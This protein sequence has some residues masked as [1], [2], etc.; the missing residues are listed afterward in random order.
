[1]NAPRPYTLIAEVTHRCP[2]ACPYCSNPLE[3]VRDELDTDAWLRVLEDYL[4]YPPL[5]A[6]REALVS[7]EIGDP[8]GL[9]MKIVAT[10]RGGWDVPM[11]SYEWQFEQARDGRGMLVFDHGWHQLAV[12]TWLLGPVRRIFGWVGATEIVPGIVMDAPSTLV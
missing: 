5:V 8:A 4:F 11:S 12:A 3:L 9:H 7:G 10:G 1:M 6:I 2:L